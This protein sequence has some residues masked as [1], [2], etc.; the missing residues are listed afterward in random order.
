[1]DTSWIR[2]TPACRPEGGRLTPGHC[3][4]RGLMEKITELLHRKHSKGHLHGCKL[5]DSASH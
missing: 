4:A 1:M 5:Y 3:R 2:H